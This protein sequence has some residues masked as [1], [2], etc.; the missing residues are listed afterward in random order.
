MSTKFNNATAKG[1][2]MKQYS[3]A[4]NKLAQTHYL[5]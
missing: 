3:G 5:A 1:E 4:N 2:E